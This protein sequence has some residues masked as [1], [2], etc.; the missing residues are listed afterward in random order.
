LQGFPNQRNEIRK[1]VV[2]TLTV[3]EETIPYLEEAD[4]QEVIDSFTG[5]RTADCH[6]SEETSAIG[7][8]SSRFFYEVDR[9]KE[10]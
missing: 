7:G 2:L 8:Y 5:P 4:I 3:L 10:K 1:I 9:F 6:R